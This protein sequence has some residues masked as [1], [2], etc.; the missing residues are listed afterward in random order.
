MSGRGTSIPARV[1]C[2]VAALLFGTMAISTAYTGVFRSK[3]GTAEL[4]P[5]G[6]AVPVLVFGAF[7]GVAGWVAVTG[8]E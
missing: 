7:A 4:S 5:L 3:F 6:R 2:G 8:R 1:M